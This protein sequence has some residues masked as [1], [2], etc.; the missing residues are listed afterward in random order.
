M[1]RWNW[2]NLPVGVKAALIVGGCAIIAA[3]IGL[4]KFSGSSSRSYSVSGTNLDHSISAAGKQTGNN[5][6]E[7]RSISM[8]QTF[9]VGQ[10]LAP[11]NAPQVNNF[12]YYY[13]AVSNSVTKEA[14]DALENKVS[15]TTNK[16]E[17]TASEVR[18]LAQAL[19]DLDQRTSDI[20]KL[21]D[22]RTKFGS[23]VT[24]KPKVLIEA[25]D[26]AVQ[27]YTNQDY[28]SALAHAKKAI[29]LAESPSGAAM[30]TGG[31]TSEGKGRLYALA[32]DSGQR[33]GSN[34]LANRFAEKAVEANP[35]G[36]NELL[37]TTTLANLG[38][39]NLR[40]NEPVVALGFLSRAVDAYV[41][42]S[43]SEDFRAGYS[44]PQEDVTRIVVL[45]VSTAQRLGS[46]DLACTIA[47]KAVSIEPTN[48]DYGMILATTFAKAGRKD[49]GIAVI[50]KTFQ[51]ESNSPT[52]TR[53][54]EILRAFP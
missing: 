49:E 36:A 52:A 6:I 51:S 29:E 26:A 1:P 37:H 2:G 11:I 41:E 43:G 28:Q 34:S 32:A 45:A 18:L 10:N 40:K 27:S 44:I 3:I 42:A 9:S 25:F 13:G 14:F 15:A 48:T 19:R 38:L 21:P 53:L 8:P 16:L 24:G 4:F 12:N 20:E 54:K 39:E 30:E 46:N 7:D 47:E 23:Y 17:L 33:L 22:G 50:D 35:S 31:I 5:T